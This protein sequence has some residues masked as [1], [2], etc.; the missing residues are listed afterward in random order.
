MD[1]DLLEFESHLLRVPRNR[2]PD[3]SSITVGIRQVVP[4]KP[5]MATLTR[6]RQLQLGQKPVPACIQSFSHGDHSRNHQ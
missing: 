1:L 6:F 4:E 5:G 2:H 3:L